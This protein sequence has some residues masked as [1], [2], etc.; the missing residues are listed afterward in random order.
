MSSTS[1]NP[2]LRRACWR[3]LGTNAEL[4]VLGD[5]RQLALAREA[6][7]DWLA[8][9]DLACSR[10]R[11]DSELSR[12]SVANG[13]A[14]RVS[15][16]LIE[17]TQLALRAARLTNGDVDPTLGTALELA[18]YD[19]DWA[20]IEADGGWQAAWRTGV[21]GS[22]AAPARRTSDPNPVPRL[23]VRLRA[24]WTRVRVDQRLGTV[25]LPRG[26]KLDLGATAKAWAADRAASVARAAGDCSGVLVSLGGDIATSGNSPAGGWRVHVTDDHRDGPDAPGQTI[27]IGSGGLATSS[28]AVRRWRRGDAQMHHIIDP[29]TGA[30]ASTPWRTV[31]V[32]AENCADANIAATAAIVRGESAVQWLSGLGLPSRLVAQDGGVTTVGSWPA[33]FS[34]APP[35]SQ[36]PVADGATLGSAA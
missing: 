24:P 5:E 34:Q 17:A 32:A 25:E 28:T 35:A 16:V 1:L 31:S 26:V 10:F 3:A 29:H 19:R 9:V 20:L 18:G 2:A 33:E 27:T 36:M 14:M 22:T 21:P 4:L 11:P 8:Q 15:L 6:V 13:R 30:P 12:L 23:R 7:E